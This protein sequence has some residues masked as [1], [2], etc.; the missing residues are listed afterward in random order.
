HAGTWRAGLD[1]LLVGVT[2]TEDDDRLFANTLPLDDVESGAI[3]LAGRIAEF[4]ERLRAAVDALSRPQ[5]LTA[6]ATAIAT[7]ADALTAT[8]PRDAW[9][10]AELQ[11]ILNGVLSDAAVAASPDLTRLS[12]PEIR[13]LLADRLQGR[14][15]RANFR[16]G[17]LT[18]CTLV[19]MRS[20]PHRVI[21]LLGLV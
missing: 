14:P 11:R 18:I 1:R 8:S 13:A 9:Q 17:H 21:C 4:V 10:R 3:D 16:T 5:S 2:M 12:L 7:A 15:T 20:V 6:W 19:P